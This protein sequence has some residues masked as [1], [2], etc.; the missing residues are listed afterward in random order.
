[1]IKQGISRMFFH[2]EKAM[3]MNMKKKQGVPDYSLPQD[4]FPQDDFPDSDLALP[5]PPSSL[6]HSSP[7]S[8]S[9]PPPSLSP[10]PPPPSPSLPPKQPRSTDTSD[11]ITLK[12]FL[13]ENEKKTKCSD[14]H[15]EIKAPQLEQKHGRS[16]N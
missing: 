16:Q 7:P 6:S 13:N 12:R 9:P 15:P 1:M 14:F 2:L 3:N 8:L 10:P 11:L 4:D 5:S